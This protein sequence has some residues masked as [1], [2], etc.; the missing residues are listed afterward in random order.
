MAAVNDSWFDEALCRGKTRLFFSDNTVSIDQAR[1]ICATCTVRQRC[2]DYAMS[3]RQEHGVWGGLSEAERIG[4]QRAVRPGGYAP[5]DIT[6]TTNA[7]STGA[8]CSAGR[9]ETGWS[10]LCRAHGSRASAG[11][12]TI[13]EFAVSRPEEWCE[14]CARIAQGIDPKVAP[15]PFGVR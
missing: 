8:T 3:T 9:S 13:A 5:T 2:L 11:S 6:Y 14:G 10:V 4:R 12:R 1:A 15:T 7:R